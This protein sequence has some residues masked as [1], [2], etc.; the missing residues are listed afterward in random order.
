MLSA[1]TRLPFQNHMPKN[2]E[3]LILINCLTSIV[4]LDGRL[5]PIVLRYL[6]RTSNLPNNRCDDH[7]RSI[8]CAQED[9]TGMLQHDNF[10]TCQKTRVDARRL[11]CQSLAQ[12]GPSTAAQQLCF[13]SSGS[14][15]DCAREGANQV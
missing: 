11:F 10:P 4:Y 12:A 1:G 6:W 13:D 7:Q 3:I 8:R 9:C 14:K 5:V 15:G 2:G